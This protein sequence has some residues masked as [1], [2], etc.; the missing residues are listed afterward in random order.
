MVTH[1]QMA[2]AYASRQLN[3]DT[4][5]IVSERADAA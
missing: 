4:G 2:A 1:D 3:L 5:Q